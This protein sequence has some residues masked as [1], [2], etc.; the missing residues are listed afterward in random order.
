[1]ITPADLLRVMPPDGFSRD[2]EVLDRTLDRVSVRQAIQ[3]DVVSLPAR[4][5]VRE[6]AAT[7]GRGGFHG[8]PVVDEHGLLLGLVTT[9]DIMRGLLSHASA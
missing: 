6:A 5:T 7:L 9:S 2:P 3:E 4:S 8:L 1:M